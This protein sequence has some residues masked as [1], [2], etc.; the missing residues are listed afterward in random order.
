MLG[1]H[2]DRDFAFASIVGLAKHEAWRLQGEQFRE[3]PVL[4]EGRIV[5]KNVLSR[6]LQTEDLGK[7]RPLLL[8][9]DPALVAT[10]VLKKEEKQEREKRK[11]R[12]NGFI[13]IF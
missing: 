3:R 12:I 13:F 10:D 4:G 5:N 8:Q 1:C 2:C 9:S 11:Y 6:C 7:A